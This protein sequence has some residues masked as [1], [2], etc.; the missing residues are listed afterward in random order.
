M[1]LKAITPAHYPWYDY[2]RYSFSLGLMTDRGAYLS[3]HTASEYDPVNKKIV[4][5]GSMTDQ[6][7]TAYAKIGAI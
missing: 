6:V 2:A 7:R 3:G 1:K 4:G 5:R